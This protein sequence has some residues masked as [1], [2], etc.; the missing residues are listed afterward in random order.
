MKRVFI[1][2]LTALVACNAPVIR[3]VNDQLQQL[4]TLLPTANWK[5][6]NGTDTSY[7]YFSRQADNSY[8]TY[9]YHLVRGDSAITNQG[10]I[11]IIANAVIW[12]WENHPLVLEDLSDSL[13]TWKEKS[14]NEKYELQKPDHSSLVLT[15]NEKKW[16]F[17]KTLPLSTFLV[18]AKF[19]YEHGT[20][21]L[22]SIEVAP[23][24]I[25]RKR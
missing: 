5:V 19:D 6:I 12:N 1:F 18:R 14:S 23:R 20:K 8:E 24:R 15:S 3:N 9:E 4:G 16:V 10:K 22:D 25:I 13:T 7:I 17:K 11:Q 21:F 2:L